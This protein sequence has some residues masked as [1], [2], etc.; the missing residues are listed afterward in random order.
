MDIVHGE[1]RIYL[2][3]EYFNLDM[4]KYLDNKGINACPRDILSIGGKVSAVFKDGL[5][6]THNGTKVVNGDLRDDLIID[7]VTDPAP[8]IIGLKAK[9]DAKKDTTG[10]VITDHLNTGANV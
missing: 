3:F 9:G 4:K 5:P 7:I 10:F 2:V 1:N 8:V 6:E